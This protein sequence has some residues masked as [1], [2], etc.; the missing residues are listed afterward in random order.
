MDTA[1][2]APKTRSFAALFG[3]RRF[4]VTLIAS[5]LMG[6]VVSPSFVIPVYVVMGRAMMIGLAALLAYGIFEQW[7]ARLPRWLARWALQILAIVFVVP[8]AVLAIYLAATPEGFFHD[9]ARLS[10]FFVLTM[11]GLFAGPWVAIAALFRQ[12]ELAL[13]TQAMAFQLERSEL[14]RKA[15]DTRLR[16]LQAQVEPHF[17]FNTLANVRELVLAGS[18]Q[19]P[20]VLDNLIT[21][22]RAA[23]PRLHDPLTTAGEELKLV[24]AYLDLMHLRMPDRLQFDVQA[25]PDTTNVRC[26]PTT[27]LTLVENAVRHGIDPSEHGGRIDVRVDVRGER[28]H[29]EVRDTG[30]GLRGASHRPGT[31][32]ETLR[33]RLA[34]VFGGHASLSITAVEPH[35]VRAEVEFPARRDAP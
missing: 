32:L 11:A 8:N 31:G 14:E 7:P 15:L 19:A 33:E 9:P 26:P 35:G 29:V 21:Y 20:V 17:L 6:I 28:C 18:S 22:L 13:R 24:R 12:S 30:V 34:L 3:W 4:M 2:P 5:G 23:L 25:G 10:G 1:L 27:V 16:M